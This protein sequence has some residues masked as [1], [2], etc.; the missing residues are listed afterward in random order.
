MQRIISVALLS[1]LV[2]G[3]GPQPED[4]PVPPR[5]STTVP[6]GSPAQDIDSPTSPIPTATTTTPP[7]D[8][9]SDPPT[10]VAS[11][12]AGDT[13]V[14]IRGLPPGPASPDT[15]APFRW[16]AALQDRQCGG[17]A[18]TATNS[19]LPEPERAMYAALAEV[20]G[21][22]NGEDGEVDW[23][24]A[25]AAFRDTAPVTDCLV[26]AARQFLGDVVAAHDA[27][28]DAVLTPGPAV[29][30]TACPVSIDT[31]EMIGPTQLI[32]T[33]PYLFDPSSARVGSVDLRV[34]FPEVELS[35]GVPVVR[36]PLDADDSF[37]LP[38][39][40][41]SSLQIVGDG[42]TVAADFVAGDLGQGTC[43]QLVEPT[44][45]D[46]ATPVG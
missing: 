30:G 33:G 25:R 3:C 26:V 37:C 22:L 23:D 45:V 14:A 18:D 24:Q 17:L 34:G 32:V 35:S 46:A 36:V 13:L 21:L 44:P 12:D 4:R 41:R 38:A 39:G 16:Y 10:R 1:L 27:A 5:P 40:E 28:P 2:V 9:T 11:D 29:D 8:E 6:S 20:C 43:D 7:G 15:P 31:V 19:S 42:Y